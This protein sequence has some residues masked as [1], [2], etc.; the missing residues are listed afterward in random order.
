MLAAWL[1][2]KSHVALVLG[3]VVALLSAWI[4]W[5][6]YQRRVETLKDS[7]ESERSLTRVRVLEAQR[8]AIIEQDKELAKVDAALDVRIADAKRA[9]I[10]HAK[11]PDWVKRIR[12]LEKQVKELRERLDG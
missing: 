4:A 8:D 9:A 12:S 2:T 10:I 11:L 6:S 3:G 7:L 5:G 1:W